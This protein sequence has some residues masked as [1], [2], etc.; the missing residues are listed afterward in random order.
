M[1]SIL[2]VLSDYHT[3]VWLILTLRQWEKNFWWEMC[4]IEYAIESYHRAGRASKLAF[5]KEMYRK[6]I[7]Y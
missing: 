3:S 6:C 5:Q 2:K 7:T 4:Y 1:L